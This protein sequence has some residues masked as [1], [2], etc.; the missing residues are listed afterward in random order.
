MLCFRG[1]KCHGE[2]LSR[3]EVGNP[4]EW[5]VVKEDLSEMVTFDRR[6]KQRNQQVQRP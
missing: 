1:G 4:G 6:P 5:E 3:K 2:K